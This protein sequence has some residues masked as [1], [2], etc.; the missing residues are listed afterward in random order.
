MIIMSPI[1]AAAAVFGY[2]QHGPKNLRHSRPLHEGKICFFEAEPTTDESSATATLLKKFAN[3]LGKFMYKLGL[4]ETLVQPIADISVTARII[5]E[6]LTSLPTSS[7]VSDI[8]EDISLDSSVYTISERQTPSH[9]PTTPHG[10]ENNSGL[11]LL[12]SDLFVERDNDRFDYSI[13]Q[14]DVL[15]MSRAASNQSPTDFHEE[16]SELICSSHEDEREGELQVNLPLS[17]IIEKNDDSLRGHTLQQD[18][19]PEFSWMIVPEDP[20]R[21][22]SIR[23]SQNVPE[24]IS[25]C[26]SHHSET[27]DRDLSFETC[28]ICQVQFQEGENPRILPCEHLF[29]IGCSDKLLLGGNSGEDVDCPICKKDLEE[30]QGESYHSD[31]VVPSWSFKRLGSLLASMSK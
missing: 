22:D 2:I 19:H 30:P 25:I 3:F 10:K 29:H 12:C 8:I 14:M 27:S 28:V 1:D 31:G 13:S 17:A 26:T 11:S 7:K 9:G 15:R 18:D 21:E 23:I 4:S 16:H 6:I 24:S 5:C 20:M